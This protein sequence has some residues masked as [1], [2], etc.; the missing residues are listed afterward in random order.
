MKA[1]LR[2][3]RNGYV[4]FIQKQGFAIIVTIC[5]GVITCT[6]VWTNQHAESYVSPTPPVG[7]HVSAAQLLQ[8]SLSQAATPSPQPTASP[9]VWLA[10]LNGASVLRPFAKETFMQIDDT[11]IWAIHDAVDLCGHVGD[12][13]Q[14]IADGT[15]L[16]TGQDQ[17]QGAWITIDHGEHVIAQ[18]AGLFLTG[19]YIAGDSVR[20]GDTIGFISNNPVW[21]ASLGPHLHIRVTRDG[22]AIDPLI[23]WESASSSS[24]K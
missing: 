13:V 16:E 14:S 5:V 18:Y 15:V 3:F 6:A 23:L 22:T 12:T 9:K 4:H 11:G 8:Q 10:P 17:L 2:R 1:V 24:Q 21:E 7:S 20:A 19:A